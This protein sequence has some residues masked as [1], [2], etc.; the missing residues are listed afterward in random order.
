MPDAHNLQGS[1]N[2]SYK[3]S[4][5]RI[6]KVFTD[7]CESF[8]T[9]VQN[10]VTSKN[11]SNKSPRVARLTR[12]N[13]RTDWPYDKNI[14]QKTPSSD[15]THKIRLSRSNSAPTLK[16]SKPLEP[17]N[18]DQPQTSVSTLSNIKYDQKIFQLKKFLPAINDSY[19]KSLGIKTN[20]IYRNSISNNK[21]IKAKHLLLIQLN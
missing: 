18:L 2:H 13:A 4:N 20:K 11:Y 12:P 21:L 15:S 14:K 1:Q 10:T 19:I 3:G 7:I 5:F 8:N 17:I 16:L 6:E 9:H